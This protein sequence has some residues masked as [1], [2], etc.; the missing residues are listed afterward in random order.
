MARPLQIIS[1]LLLLL[2]VTVG[3]KKDAWT[4][5]GSLDDLK[6]AFNRDRD[7]A[8]IVLLLSPT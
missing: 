2:L 6:Q 5:L 4:T 7:K 8:R 3:C 1:I